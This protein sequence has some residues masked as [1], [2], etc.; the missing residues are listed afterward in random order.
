M[1]TYPWGG[2]AAYTLPVN[3]EA[4]YY[5]S[6]RSGSNSPFSNSNGVLNI[7][8]TKAAAGSNPYN[9]PYT[10]GL[11]TTNKSFTQTYGYFETRAQLPA[12]QGLWPAFWLVGAGSELDV[13]EVLGNSPSTL[14]STTHGS[15]NGVWGGVGQAFTVPD[16]SAGFHTYGV[17]W[18]PTTVTYY[19]DGVKLGSAPTPTS[20]SVPMYMLLNLAVGG[21]GS[22]P[23]APDA[24]TAFP[25]TMQ[26]DYVRAYA[27]AGTT[28]SG[29][30]AVLPTSPSVVIGSGN[31]TLSLSISEDAYQ[32]DAQFTISVDGTQVGGIQTTNA[33]HMAGVSQVFKVMGNYS[34][35]SHTVS[36]NFLN[37]LYG[38]TSSTDRNLYLDTAS[39][40]G[41]SV[42]NSALSLMSNGAQSF[43][44]MAASTAA[45]Y[46]PTT[47]LGSGND[48]LGLQIAEDAYQGNAQFVIRV[49]GTQIGGV[50]T[51][52]AL[53]SSG[54]TQAFN[55]KGNFAVGAHAVSVE[56]LND[57]WGGTSTTDRN[58][59]VQSATINNVAVPSSHLSLMGAGAQSIAFQ[60]A[61]PG[62]DRLTLSMS[63]DAWLGDA[64][65]TVS[66]DGKQLAGT[67]TATASHAAGV[68]TQQTF[69]GNWGKGA[70]TIGVNFLNDAWGG[71]S[72]HDRNL[73][74]NG[75]NYDGAQIAMNTVSAA[76]WGGSQ[77]AVPTTPDPSNF[78]LHLSEDAYLG[79]ANFTVTVDGTQLG[80]VQSV[81]A[82]QAAGGTQAF[83][84]S[85]VLAAGAHDV[86]VS[87]INDLYGG[88]ASTDR[89][90]YVRGAELN[91]TSLSPTSWTAAMLSNG[92]NHFTLV[93]P[94]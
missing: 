69:T 68:T 3:N 73:Y 25:A 11:I 60:E 35:G 83:N 58:L 2:E 81:S 59:Y 15:T 75:V 48:V 14:Y 29:G 93:V 61:A 82:L 17:D 40:D 21:A 42:T 41:N 43:R 55:V 52:T 77:I 86:G 45:P 70:H 88:S 72:S 57:A 37:D 5:S 84:F 31:N 65:Y 22:W 23:G 8:A 13:F 38:G 26:V 30:P 91:G 33:N 10:S 47:T 76:S 62:P 90:L 74:V 63:E 92:T 34:A 7:T 56:F 9:L 71:D 24:S 4:E 80:G 89:N 67:Y 53:R 87:F 64:N 20:M 85:A 16:T 28:F 18:E 79:D 78:T 44:F 27:T 1:T 39:V 66:V 46:S 51:A 94:S 54:S 36:L 19:M 50:Q 49:D 32:G 6:D 12:G